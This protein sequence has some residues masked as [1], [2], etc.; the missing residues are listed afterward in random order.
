[1]KSRFSAMFTL[2]VTVLLSSACSGTGDD[3]KTP[4]EDL[5]PCKVTLSAESV[6]ATDG[7]ATVDVS[8]T[9]FDQMRRLHIVRH[10]NEGDIAVPFN[11]EMISNP[12]HFEYNITDK[13]PEDLAIDFYVSDKANLKSQTATLH[14][15]NSGPKSGN[16]IKA[17]GFK[18]VSR[19]TGKEDNGAG[20][21][22]T[23]YA[24]F[25]NTD[26]KYDV[27]GTDLGI[28]WEITPGR[29][30]MFF[31]DTYGVDFRPT[32][33]GGGNGNNWRSNVLL[34]SEDR[35]LFDGMTISGAATDSQGH[36]REI[37]R[38]AHI[39]NGSGDWTSIPTGAVHANG[40]EYVHYM[41]IKN[42][43]GW[44]AGYSSFYKST[45]E[46]KT[47][48]RVPD[49]DFESRSN[50][51]QV[52]M[53]N[54]KGY[55]YIVGT[56]TGRSSSPRLARVKEDKLE[57]FASYE[58]WNGLGWVENKEKSAVNLFEDTAGELSFA[59]FPQYDK[60]II[61]YIKEKRG[62]A[63][64]D[65]ITLRYADKITGPWSE[66]Q[67]LTD[68]KSF[69]RPYGSFI[70]PISLEGGNKLYFIMSVWNAYNS[71]LIS[72]DINQ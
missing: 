71:Y 56:V 47:W 68:G 31:G 67:V 42:W 2:L 40:A 38:S 57:D 37:C 50:F 46:A 72:L 16:A 32:Q 25:N 49:A 15:L 8:F 63:I 66:P 26:T 34:F 7:T 54:H 5:S 13:D 6:T 1:M 33:G 22:Q 12:F 24:V 36:A 48:S 39:T 53:F 52:G 55:V 4:S 27:G 19:I 3:R 45:D 14:V 58:Y 17:S 65:E 69:M 35:T 64:V 51:G 9:G 10:T 61:L 20:F 43:Y 18:V 30:G 28:I 59:Y 11:K 62:D 21:P 23:R 29:Y 44:V 70:H 41:N 60:W